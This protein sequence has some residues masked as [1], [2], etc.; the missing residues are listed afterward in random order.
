MASNRRGHGVE[1][2]VHAIQ[3]LVDAVEPFAHLGAQLTNTIAHLRAQALQDLDGDVIA[4][5]CDLLTVARD[6]CERRADV[7][8]RSRSGSAP[9]RGRTSGDCPLFRPGER[10]KLRA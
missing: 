7:E 3:T 6:V 9:A 4:R 2:R 1:P 8:A 5:H 10:C